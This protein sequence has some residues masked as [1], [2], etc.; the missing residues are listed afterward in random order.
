MGKRRSFSAEEKLKIVME[1][2]KECNNISEVCRRHNIHSSQF[3]DWKEKTMLVAKEGLKPKRQGKSKEL[4]RKD[5]KLNQL[6]EVLV[7]GLPN[8]P[9]V[10]PSCRQS[11]PLQC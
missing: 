3:Y 11:V 2:L 5:E 9:G 4:K 1:C 8:T 7:S 10:L 6:N